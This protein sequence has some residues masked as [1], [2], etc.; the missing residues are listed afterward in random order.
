MKAEIGFDFL[1]ASRLT[2]LITTDSFPPIRLAREWVLGKVDPGGVRFVSGAEPPALAELLECNWCAGMYVAA[3]VVAARRFLPGVWGPL[4]KILA[5]SMVVGEVAG[6]SERQG[7]LAGLGKTLD[8]VG[9]FVGSS[10]RAVGA[11]VADAL[12][13]QVPEVVSSELVEST[14]EVPDHTHVSA[15]PTPTSP[16]T[17][18]G[19]V[20]RESPRTF[21]QFKEDNRT[22]EK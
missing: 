2:R 20:L 12:R 7:D 21:E 15:G 18:V 11:M 5:T 4:A 22:G 6:L 10:I 8:G 16:L 9:L 17:T 14:T 3:G 13:E 19:P 1:A